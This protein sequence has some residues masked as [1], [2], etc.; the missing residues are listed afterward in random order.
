[1]KRI[2][3][4]LEFLLSCN[5]EDLRILC[6]I[7]TFTNDGKYRLTEKLT[8]TDAYLINYPDHMT[9][10]VDKIAEEILRCGSNSV[11]TLLRSGL[12]DTYED[13]LRRVCKI[14][15]VDISKERSAAGMEQRL[16]EKTFQI[17]MERM[18][19]RELRELAEKAGIRKKS[20]NKQVLLAALLFAMKRN[21][22]VLWDVFTFISSRALSLMGGRG[23]TILGTAIF[24]R[25][26]GI[27][28][29]PV[30]TI[31]LTV[32]TIWD[33]AAPAYRVVVPAVIQVA[34]MR[35]SASE[36]K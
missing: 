32:W 15:H 12:P 31:V 28:T 19:E 35:L 14:L 24:P 30:G 6:D 23:L 34:I 13:V 17:T 27:L 8:K 21:R 10:M 3:K 2:D 29:G 4:D 22:R 36:M 9:G 7:L 16:L 33:L 20:L 18:T 25:T 26:L 1:M 11:S 5:N